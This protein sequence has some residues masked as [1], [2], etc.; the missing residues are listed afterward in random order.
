[1][2]E[3]L[4]AESSCLCGSV[5]I[6]ANCINPNFE[7][8]HCGMC[9]KWGGGPALALDCGTEIEIKGQEHITI[10]DSS[11][12]AQ[13]AF[14]DKCGTHLFYKIKEE[15]RYIIPVGFFG[16]LEGLEFDKQYFIDKKPEYYC[17]SNK[18]ENL[19]EAEVYAL[20]APDI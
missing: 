17:F 14:C 13:R 3:T 16:S 8:C 2:T 1:M 15:E 9:Q 19:T 4:S 12:W 10:Y 7:A 11:L 5:S 18:T 20:Y 6:R